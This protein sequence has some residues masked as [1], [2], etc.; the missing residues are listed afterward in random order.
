MVQGKLCALEA[1]HMMNDMEESEPSMADM[2]HATAR[3]VYSISL[4]L[5]IGVLVSWALM[6]NIMQTLNVIETDRLQ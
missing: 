4:E 6:V 2:E 3:G 1:A 5:L